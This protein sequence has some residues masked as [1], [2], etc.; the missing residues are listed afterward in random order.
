MKATVEPE[1]LSTLQTRLLDQLSLE[2]TPLP[3]TADAPTPVVTFQ[4]GDIVLF[5]RTPFERSRD[6]PPAVGEALMSKYL[7]TWSLPS[8]VIRVRETTLEVL[9]VGTGRQRS[10]SVQVHLPPPTTSCLLPPAHRPYCRLI[11]TT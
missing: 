11:S 9:E 2:D 1:R 3:S 6:S 7:P 10:V 5:P 8:R 4:V